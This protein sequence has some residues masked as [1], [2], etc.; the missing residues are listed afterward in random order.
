MA[1]KT[2][3]SGILGI[4]VDVSEIALSIAYLDKNKIN[5]SKT[6]HIPTEYK[7]EGIIKP[8]SLNNDF[9]SDKQK[10]VSSFKD[11][12]KK[13]DFKTSRAVVSLSHD[14]SIT[15]FFSMPFIERKFWNKAIP[16]ESKKY[17][18]VS[19][20]ELAY[21]FYAYPLENN[22]KVGVCFSVTQKKTTEFLIQLLKQT[23]IE[24]LMAE[25]SAVSM[26]RFFSITS[27]NKDPSVLVYVS[28]D[29]VYTAI[30]SENIPVVF[31][32]ISFSKSPAF[33][34]RKSLNLKGSMLFAQ[35]TLP[36]VDIN[37]IIF[38]GIG[39]DKWSEQ[40][41]KETS[42]KPEILKMD[43]KINT[44][45]FKFSTIMSASASVK[46]QRKEKVSI[47]ISEVEKNK[48]L[49]KTIQNSI[50]MIGGFVAGLFILL[51][52]INSLR[53]YFIR[54]EI[55]S[56]MS[57]MPEISEFEGLTT[58][59][60][61]DKLV[62]MRKI[63]NLFSKIIIKRDYFAPKM[64]D[65]C[66]VI[67]KDMWL[68][69]MVYTNPV[70][71]NNEA[72]IKIEFTINGETYLTGESRTYYM[73]YFMKEIKK[74]KNFIIC[75]PPL[76]SIDYNVRDAENFSMDPKAKAAPAVFRISCHMDKSKL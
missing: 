6:I 25:P 26:I 74:S 70:T 38:A 60:A 32:Y 58:E 48:R 7:T 21:D 34:E 43:E 53:N 15:R 23:G 1:K 4:Y 69:E 46:Y 16:I 76:G 50:F 13:S 54:N 47:D 51:L 20:D 57:K 28:E 49:N 29:E 67:P 2:N 12:I 11:I 33:S 22:S 66:D 5:I 62:K 71:I 45:D 35:R 10:W 40:A 36:N 30:D 19:F 3:E 31:R 64:S 27:E 24:L 73:D 39:G 42:I 75:N 14:F 59:Q 56:Y 44:G 52:F 41:E 55:L 18:P 9:F 65:M 68:K 63:K 61:N 72:N 8:L 37:K 17:I